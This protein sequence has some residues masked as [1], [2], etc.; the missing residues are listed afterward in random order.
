MAPM[1]K[2]RAFLNSMVAATSIGLAVA[3]SP[4]HRIRAVAQSVL[5]PQPAI[6]PQNYKPFVVPDDWA[7]RLLD[8]AER[9]VGET[10]IYDPS[11]VRLAYP[12]GDVPRERGVCTDVV[13]RAFR[14]AFAVDLQ[15]LVHEDMRRN[16]AA[17]PTYWGAKGPDRNIDHRRVLNLAA[18]FRRKGAGL[19]VSQDAA[20]YLPGDII[21]QMLPGNRPHMG[22]VSARANDRDTRPMILHNIGAGARLEDTLF[23]YDITGRYRYRPG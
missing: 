2:R 17:Y 23:A 11:Y 16:F 15:K 7:V 14:D 13:V 6:P 1:I 4:S 12:G 18:Y 22:I 9:Q 8:A 19:P 5:D 10:V 21:A 3:V 20:D